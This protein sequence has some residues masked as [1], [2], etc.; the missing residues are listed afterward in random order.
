MSVT[1]VGPICETGDQ[2]GRARLFPETTEGDVV[3]VANTG[4]YGRVMASQYNLRDP[5]PEIV[6]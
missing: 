1:I 4:A 2:L 5:A 3:L 6:I